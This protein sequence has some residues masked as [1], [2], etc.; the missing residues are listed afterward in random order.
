MNTTNI[1]LMNHFII[2]THGQQPPK[3]HCCIDHKMIDLLH[4]LQNIMNV[5]VDHIGLSGLTVGELIESL[6]KKTSS[7]RC[8]RIWPGLRRVLTEA[9]N[10]N[11]PF[12]HVLILAGTND[13]ASERYGFRSAEDIL[14]VDIT[15]DTRSI[16]SMAELQ[17]IAT[18][19]AY[20][21]CTFLR[22]ATA[23]DLLRLHRAVQDEVRSHATSPITK[24][25]LPR[26]TPRSSPPRCSLTHAHR[27]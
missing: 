5:P 17:S 12:S 24:P 20:T 21:A 15:A 26:M 8:G 22:H 2:S 6:D 10:Q 18:L 9:K 4:R 11:S 23:Q 7:D 14:K 25:P 16:S 3:P 19:A 13:L 27:G 1:Y